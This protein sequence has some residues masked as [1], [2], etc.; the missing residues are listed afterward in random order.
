MISIIVPIY[1]TE[2]Y[3]KECIESILGQTYAEIEVILVDDGSPDNCGKI[4]DE[5][6][7]RDSRIKV[8]HKEN[9]GLV[10]ARQAGLEAAS[11][12]Y[13]GFVDGDDSIEPEMYEA[14][15][16]A[17]E[18]YSPDVICSEFYQSF[19]ERAEASSQCF[20]EGFYDKERLIKEIYPRMLYSGRYYRFGISPNCWSK[21]FK[22]ELLKKYLPLVDTKIRMGEDAAFTYPCLL[23]AKSVYCVK[24]PLYKYRILNS[25]M[26]RGYDEGLEK[27][28]FLPYEAIRTANKRSSFDISEQL[29]YYHIYLAN[30]AV[31]NA[32]KG[33]KKDR[34]FAEKLLGNTELKKNADTVIMENLPIHTRFLV[35]AIR[36]SRVSVLKL[37][38]RGMGLYLG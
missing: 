37:Y 2:K 5:Y 4:C 14:M 36:K 28:I 21:L 13:I 35:N 33:G 19:E 32:A 16:K 26:S 1:K 15:A 25:S 7:K 10:S 18:E 17:A 24:K 23:D 31:R 11:G 34:N 22:K 9:G 38:I 12:D 6:A 20:E 30:F 27:I 8:I 3:I 29:A